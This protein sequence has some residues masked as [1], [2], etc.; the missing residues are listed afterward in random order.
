[1]GLVSS[2]N[3]ARTWIQKWLSGEERNDAVL[4]CPTVD[5]LWRDSV[6][7]VL[8]EK[9]HQAWTEMPLQ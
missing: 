3:L 7:E 5:S 8:L 2:N 1:M 6:V 4:R 9:Q